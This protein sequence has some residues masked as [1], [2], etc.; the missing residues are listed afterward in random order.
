MDLK[1]VPDLHFPQ[2]GLTVLLKVDV[3]REM[4]VDISHLVFEAPRYTSDHVLDDG[5][6]G[7]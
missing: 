6:D 1:H 3:D 2:I 4:C 5:S 7:P